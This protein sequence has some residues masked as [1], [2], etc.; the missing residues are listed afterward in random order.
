[1]KWCKLDYPCI[2]L[3]KRVRLYIKMFVLLPSEM[4]FCRHIVLVVS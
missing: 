1:M 2:G 3:S 4:N